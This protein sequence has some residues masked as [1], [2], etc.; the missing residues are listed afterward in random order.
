MVSLKDSLDTTRRAAE[1]DGSKPGRIPPEA[2]A[3]MHRVTAEQRASGYQA[4][5]P[6]VGQP[7]PAF[8]LANQDGTDVSSA[9]LVARGPL[10]VS[11]FR[12]R[13]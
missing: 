10:V 6:K 5:M 12:G 1:G 4:N 7:G 3:I 13:W 8:T 2:L 11:F 9:A